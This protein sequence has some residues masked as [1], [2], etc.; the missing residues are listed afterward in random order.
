MKPL[1]D[2]AKRV[3]TDAHQ[4]VK[5]EKHEY[6]L[7]EHLMFALLKNNDIQNFVNNFNPG[8]GNQLEHN[9]REYF[10]MIPDLGGGF[11]NSYVVANETTNVM[12][13]G[14]YM[15]EAAGRQEVDVFDLFLGI[16]SLDPSLSFASNYLAQLVSAEPEKVKKAISHA[17]REGVPQYKVDP[18]TGKKEFTGKSVLAQ[19]AVNL[20]QMARDGKIDPV[21]GR[22]KEITRVIQTLNRKKKNN[23]ALVG[24]AGVGKTAVVEGLALMIAKG[25]VPDGVKDCDIYA[26]NMG[27]L[28]AGTQYRGDFE[29]RVKK[30]VDEAKAK[31]NVILFLDEM[32]TIV[33]AGATSGGSLDASNILKPALSNGELRVIGATTYDEY[34]SH[35]LKDKALSRRF[36]KID[37][38]EPSNNETEAIIMGL[39]GSYEKHHKVKYD[40]A[41]VSEAVKLSVKHI[42]ERFLPDKAI[43]LID[44]AGAKNSSR[45]AARKDRITIDDLRE[46]VADHAN[47]PQAKIVEDEMVTLK[48]L[49]SDIK[50]VIFGQDLAVAKVSRAIK[51]ARSGL[52]GREK[53][54]FSGLFCGMSGTGKTELAKQLAK[55]LSMNFVRLD[56]SEYSTKETVSKLIGTSPGYVGFEQAGTLTEPL[57]KNPFSVV[58]LDE[59]EK[60]DK[61]VFNTL[62]QIMDYGT[63]TDNN[64]RKADFRN[65]MVI[66]TSN[67][68]A[69]AMSS[70][71]VNIGF[72]TD[73]ETV[74]DDGVKE[75]VADTFSPEF[76]NRLDAVVDFNDLST[77]MLKMIVDK[78]INEWT[79]TSE[80]K[81]KNITVTLTDEVKQYIVDKGAEEKLGAR[82]LSR[83]VRNEIQEPLV[84]EIMFGKLRNGGEV[85]VDLDK[86]SQTVVL[87][88]K[89]SK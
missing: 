38:G 58:L 75:A 4:I 28:V 2:D 36:Q 70:N 31:P 74:K 13:A 53:P 19:F 80:F 39:L 63:L 47:I 32:H 78:F 68:G 57:I 42:R 43:D 89:G 16:Y 9:L 11:R 45:G 10:E 65:A 77:D 72:E 34:K 37:V 7:P 14:E 51:M 30:L 44:E 6:L 8:A 3:I 64:G 25:E 46:V 69:P 48:N 15:A 82:P 20:T 22:K 66:M 52:F 24:E 1:N 88:V 85:K 26:L 40:E 87:K 79:S 62:L 12:A 21:I 61:N 55:K 76:R 49:E 81:A 56:M 29:D 84:D 71:K 54:I 33:G 59:I 27:S 67:V 5:K 35:I 50:K 17:R 23:P 73:V 86:K 83:I 60:A 18:V 41:C